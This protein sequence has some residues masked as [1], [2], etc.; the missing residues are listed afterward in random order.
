[1]NAIG[2]SETMVITRM[3]CM[4]ERGDIIP[5]PLK[6]PGY[7]LV[8]SLNGAVSFSTKRIG[9]RLSVL[10]LSLIHI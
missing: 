5:A 3:T 4:V 7:D 10:T 6:Y 9:T 1:M 2:K 8:G